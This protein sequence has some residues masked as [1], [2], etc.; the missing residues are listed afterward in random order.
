MEVSTVKETLEQNISEKSKKR[1]NNKM[2]IK[3]IKQL[4]KRLRK[5]YK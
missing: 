1:I 5:T 4:K 2:K 3:K